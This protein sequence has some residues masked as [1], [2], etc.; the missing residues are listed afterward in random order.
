VAAAAAQLPTARLQVPAELQLPPLLALR[1][2]LQQQEPEQRPCQ[3]LLL[4]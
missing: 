1:A 3:R 2:C 4:A